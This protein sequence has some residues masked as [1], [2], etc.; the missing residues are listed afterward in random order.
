MN[1]NIGLDKDFEKKFQELKCEY[2]ERLAS[3]N[4][5]ADSQLNYNDFIDNFI[6][7]KVV[8]D[9]SIDPNANVGHKDVITLEHEMMKPHDKLLA[10]NKI[11][12]EMKK[13]FSKE[14]ADEWF[15]LEYT[16]ALYLHD[17]P[18]SSKKP[19]CYAYTLKDLAER[20][21]YFIEGY[22]AEPAKHLGTFVTF[23]KEFVSYNSNR[24]SGA[25][26]LPNL[27]PY[28]Y[29]FWSRDVK[30]GYYTETPEKY[31]K[32]NIQSFIYAINQPYCRDGSQSAFTNTNIFDHEYLVALFG[33]EQF[34][35]GAF[36]YDE[37]EGIMEFQ[38]MFLEEMSEVRSQN[39]FTFPVNSI[40]LIK[41]DGIWADEEFA[42]WAC[43]HNRKWNDSNF[44][45]DNSV[46]SLSNCCR[47]KSSIAD[48]GF[49]NSIGGTALRVGSIKVSTINLARIAYQSKN[50]EEYIEKLQHTMGVNLKL[51]HVVRSIIKRNIEKGLLPNY[52][53]G[54]IDINTQYNTCGFVG[55][56]ETMKYFGYTYI[57]KFDN[58][59]YNDNAFNFGKRI[60]EA[61]HQ[62]K[63]EFQK[64]KDYQCNL[65]QAPAENCAIKLQLA[66][67][68]F[69]PDKV[70]KDLPLYA[71]QFIGLGIKTTMK[72]RIRIASAFDKYCSGGSILH[73]NIEA[74][75]SNFT[76]AWDMLNYIT[77][78]GVTYFAFNTK[79]QVCKNN[80]AFFGKKCPVCG[81]DVEGEYTRIVGFYT[82][83]ST[84]SKE[85]KEEFKLRKWADTTN[86]NTFLE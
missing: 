30:Q 17:A 50:E 34:P 49:F 46:T 53:H 4:G 86:E 37:I 82:K 58:T 28:L 52:K 68:F 11:Y 3:L 70:V 40:S 56:Y 32:Q 83:I 9:S 23:L 75:F 26:G 27:I 38:K 25:C 85:R 76:Q 39:M 7:T 19:Y 14:D 47:L 31:A 74:P 69:Y 57:D 59:F 5:L 66:D 61:M 24:T 21:L 77:D 13:Q 44:F 8:A 29:Y 67:E 36:M 71:N 78:Q 15:E 60:F 63:N 1:I 16:R 62:V 2:G 6:D 18:T 79:I 84:W 73:A 54:L 42:R 80:H 35:D 12:Y 20:G 45:V 55:I 43:E 51:L 33:G 81:G 65:E 64:N 10:L 22:N 41:K 72:E 48:L